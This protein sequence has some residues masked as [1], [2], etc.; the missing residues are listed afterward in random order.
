MSCCTLLYD[1][2]N[3]AW[4]TAR[5]ASPKS[6]ADLV[7]GWQALQGLPGYRGSTNGI[8]IA[9]GSQLLARAQAAQAAM[10]GQQAGP[11]SHLLLG[12]GLDPASQVMLQRLQQQAAQ[13]G[14]P[15]SS[16]MQDIS[17]LG[18]SGGAH[19]FISPTPPPFPAGHSTALARLAAYPSERLALL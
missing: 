6:S 9:L 2:L 13:R 16:P 4:V 10:G 15:S 5:Q 18:L 1:L 12:A 17:L 8:G 19:P 14:T 3:P 7:G 11:G